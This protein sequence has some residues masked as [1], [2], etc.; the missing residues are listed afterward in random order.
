LRL[1]GR[2]APG[3]LLESRRLARDPR[4]HDLM[5]AVVRVEAD[6]RGGTGF[7]LDADGLV[8][9]NEHI[10][11]DALRVAVDFGGND[12]FEVDMWDADTAADLAVLALGSADLPRLELERESMPMPGEEVL[13]I[14]NPLGLFRI[15]Q[16]STVLGYVRVAGRSRPVMRLDGPVRKG[17]SGS[18]VLNAEGRVVGVVYAATIPTGK[19]AAEALAIPATDIAAFVDAVSPP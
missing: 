2:P 17:N 5:Q 14:G 3:L 4:I 9:T 1:I 11:E 19:E 8:V 18:P 13:V 16:R 15:V 10:T 6:N 7:N 12:R